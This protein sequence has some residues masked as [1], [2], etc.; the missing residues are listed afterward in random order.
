MTILTLLLALNAHADLGPKPTMKFAWKELGDVDLASLRLL[1]CKDESCK[2]AKPLMDAG[3]QHFSCA[4]EQCGAL[5]Y[6]FA[7][8]NQLA[9]KTKKGKDAKSNV[10]K[11]AGME[12]EYVVSAKGA[13]IDV[14]P[15]PKK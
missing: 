11:A 6:G 1:Q 4:E 13:A 2:D 9:G 15:A 12:S 14:K 5:A 8:F 3:P 7:E 10:F